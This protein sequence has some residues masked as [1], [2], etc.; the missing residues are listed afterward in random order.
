MDPSAD[1]DESPIISSKLIKLR[2]TQEDFEQVATHIAAHHPNPASIFKTLM[3][4]SRK[5]LL[6]DRFRRLDRTNPKVIERLLSFEG[7]LEYL[8]LLGFESTS[9]QLICHEKPQSWIIDTSIA[10]LKEFIA[11]FEGVNI[12]SSNKETNDDVITETKENTIEEDSLRLN[13]IIVWITHENMTDSTTSEI[14]II[15][16]KQFCKSID[17]LKQLKNRFFIKP[18]KDIEI[19]NKIELNEWKQNIEKKIQLKVI[20]ILIDWIKLYW[21]QDFK[22]N[23]DGIFD[24]LKQF[25]QEIKIKSNVKYAEMIEKIIKRFECGLCVVCV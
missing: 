12:L 1:V 16:H 21:N 23:K 17:L 25:I 2:V 7:V 4:I 9:L 10:V 13:Q 19:N 8:Q 3:T 24:L 14:L 18:P 22:H 6:N 15:S 11:K 5:V 20:K